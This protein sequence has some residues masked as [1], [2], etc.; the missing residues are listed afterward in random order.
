MHSRFAV[1]VCCLVGSTL[2]LTSVA[3]ALSAQ[4]VSSSAIAARAPTATADIAFMQ[5][6]LMH[7]E[8]AVVMSAMVPTR[9]TRAALRLLAERVAV[10]QRDEVAVMRR[11]LDEH[12]ASS[13]SH[14]GHAMPGMLS[15]EQI[16]QLSAASGATFDR[17]FLRFMIQHHAG[18]LQMVADLRGVPGAVQSSM[19]FQFL[20]DID[21]D[22]RSEIRR[23][24]RLLAAWSQ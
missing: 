18:A 5:G 22:Q 15:P 11:W 9:T 4:A 8:Q 20:N 16:A 10:S 21:N 2:A 1:R 12:G 23:M 13:E 7:H 14:H 24:Q 6:M 17:L 3:P 19:L